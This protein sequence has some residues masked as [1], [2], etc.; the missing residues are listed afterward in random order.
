MK[1]QGRA[2]LLLVSAGME[3][4]YLYAWATF[5]STS[6]FYQTF[7]FPEAVGSFVLAG[8]LTLLSAGRG[9]RVIYILGIQGVGFITALLGMVK[10]LD[11]WSNP[12]LNQAWFVKYYGS[13]PGAVI[14]LIGLLVLWV[15]VFWAGGVGLARRPRDYFTVCSRFDR[16][17]VAFFL[18]YVT[19]F[20]LRVK[21]SIHI[22]GP[23]PEFFLFPF[24]IFG[25]LAI[26]LTRN[27]SGEPRDFLQGYGGI[28]VIVS[29]SVVVLL[30]GAGLV[31]FCLPYLTMA[32]EEGYGI[33]KAAAGPIGS[34]LLK[35]LRFIFGG[36]LGPSRALP[37]RKQASMPEPGLTPQ[38]PTPWWLELLGYGL[39]VLVGVLF[40]IIVG[41]AL[42]Y[43]Y[44]WLISRTPVSRENQSPL[45]LISLFFER[46]QHLLRSFWRAL[47]LKVTGCTNA[48]Q[49][50]AALIRWGRHSGLH[51]IPS[52][53]PAEYGLRLKHRFPPLK[54]DIGSIIDAFNKEVYGEIILNKQQ[55][56]MI[57]SSWRRLRNP[58]RWPSRM[59]S[60]FRT[61]VD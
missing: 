37:E 57:Q 7:P 14:W 40:L 45:Y 55:L 13:S 26:G 11:F 52:E 25:L 23:M 50:Y 30:V 9:W 60:W 27:R 47:L 16:G 46:L 6:I 22:A 59:K 17:L 32:A 15:C 34:L 24:L 61:P 42:Y 43:L 49:L 5:I 39:L 8:A 31:L 48:V 19:T 38:G 36:K 21:G 44:R 56:A 51:H 2:L 3:L 29:F 35:I 58:L 53:T 12:I 10:V 28:G 33:L 1:G 4:C 41:V 18:L 54:T 20:L